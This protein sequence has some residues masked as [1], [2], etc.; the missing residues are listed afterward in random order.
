VTGARA[1]A[2]AL[3]LLAGIAVATWVHRM[4]VD[5]HSPRVERFEVDTY[6]YFWPTAV[7]LHDELSRG[8]LPLWNPYQLAG[9]PF[10]ALHVPTVLYPPTL[11]S[12]ALLPPHAAL[13]A[14]SVLHVFLAGLFT[15]LFAARLGLPQTARLAAAATYMLCRP[16]EI[17]FY[18]PP[19]L[20]APAWLPA[21]LWAIHGLASEARA[22][23]TVALGAALALAFLGGHAQAFV[24]ELQIAAAYGVWA[25]LRIAPR[26]RRAHVAGLAGLAGLLAAGLAAPQL[27]PALELARLGVRGL[28]GIPYDQAI[29]SSA[30]PGRLL[31]GLLRGAA[32]SG[33]GPF[34]PLL[35]LPLLALPLAAV[36][37]V[38]PARRAH[39]LFFG[40]AA[41][42]V[43]L[44]MLGPH[45]PFFA[46][47]YQLPLGNLFRGPSRLAFAWSFLFAM[48]LG[49]GIAAV[50]ELRRGGRAPKALAALLALGVGA[51]A[52]ALTRIGNAHPVA[53]GDYPGTSPEAI[54]F[55]REDP[56]RSRVFVE[57]FDVYSIRS[58]DKLGMVN[59]VF[60]VPDY[61]PSMPSSYVDYFRPRTRQPWHGRL[62][63][64]AGRDPGREAHRASL[65]LLDLMAVGHYLLE[66]P[67]PPALVQG[68]AAATG[69]PGRPLGDA[70]LFE[71]AEAVPRA[72]AVRRVHQEPDLRAALRR[73]EQP[74]FR[75]REE[76]VVVGGR[77]VGSDALAPGGGDGGSAPEAAD[78]VSISRY[79]AER[80]VVRAA[81]A[82]RC[83]LVLPDLHYPGW[84]AEVDGREAPIER[85]NAIFRGVWLEPGAHEVVFRFA[86][87]SFRL[88]CALFAT[89]LV[90]GGGAAL[91]RR[92]YGRARG[93]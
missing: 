4:E 76:A 21:I 2:L 84:R 42:V 29:L 12:L 41:V 93:A 45:T 46:V 30:D 66:M 17:G 64:F 3:G 49:I 56:T 28:A 44:V 19:Y 43:A 50:S 40:V 16:L 24:Y 39:S 65:R 74:A 11:V 37:L 22:R 78:A 67:A 86:P 48:L 91:T 7:F 89:T 27:L 90:A 71:R 68:L 23:W 10:L 62:H 52:Y 85:T 82:A 38:A 69:S 53:T 63:V 5:P 92:L 13:A 55:L 18:M 77:A 80:V 20:A 32:P 72:Y 47:Y 79:E 88:G 73:L 83:L 33:V 81:C 57:S 9:Q 60:A 59:G 15:W 35:G 87:A 58:L 1:R 8:H 75:P 26:E 70:L 34:E 14:Q 6:R 36:A 61:E 25:W 51:D 31:R 54:A